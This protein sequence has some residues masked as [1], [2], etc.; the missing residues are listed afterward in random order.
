MAPAEGENEDLHWPETRSMCRVHDAEINGKPG[1]V[2]IDDAGEIVFH[3]NNR[4]AVW[5][6]VVQN[7]LEA[8]Q[9]H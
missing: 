8:A 1:A 9:L 4:S 6:W 3:S 7:D 2:C 5:F